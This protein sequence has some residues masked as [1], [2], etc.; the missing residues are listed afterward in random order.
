MSSPEQRAP[1][2]REAA[3]EAG[4]SLADSHGVEALT[5]RKLA[6]GLGY[7]VMALYN[8]VANKQELLALMVLSLIHI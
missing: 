3:V 5:M 2:S 7:R 4:I 8:H 1:L 6:D